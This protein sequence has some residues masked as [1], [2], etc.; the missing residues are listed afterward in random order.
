VPVLGVCVLDCGENAYLDDEG[1]CIPLTNVCEDID[2]AGL[3]GEGCAEWVVDYYEDE[4]CL[5]CSDGTTE[6]ND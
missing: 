2:T 6:Y 3:C 1:A 4:V 5:S